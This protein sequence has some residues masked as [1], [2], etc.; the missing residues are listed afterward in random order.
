MEVPRHLKNISRLGDKKVLHTL[1]IS[2]HHVSRGTAR[3]WVW[4]E[5]PGW[6]EHKLG[7]VVM[8]SHLREPVVFE[9]RTS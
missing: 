9:G 1:D 4:L 7:T 3:L 6:E 2:F 5:K 8:P